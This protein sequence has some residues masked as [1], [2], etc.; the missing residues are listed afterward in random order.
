MKDIFLADLFL[1]SSRRNSVYGVRYWAAQR[2]VDAVYWHVGKMLIGTWGLSSLYNL[3][4]A[5]LG[6]DVNLRKCNVMS[7]PDMLKMG[8]R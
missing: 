2:M 8:V 6:D 4:G 3:F 7:V 1:F 5:H